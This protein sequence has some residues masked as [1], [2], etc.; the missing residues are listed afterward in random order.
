MKFARVVFTGAGIWGL[1]ILTPLFFLFDLVGRS[2]PPAITH[3]DFYFGFIGVSLAWQLGFLV[4]GMDPARFRPM[5]IPAICEKAFYVISLVALY[6][7]GRIELGQML[8]GVPDLILGL[9]FIGAFYRTREYATA[10]RTTCS[11]GRLKP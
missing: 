4:I 5:M 10:G 8:V 9:L 2:Y 11:D 7:R 1:I 3:P 6:E